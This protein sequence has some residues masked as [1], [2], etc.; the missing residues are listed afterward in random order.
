[1][2]Y[3]KYASQQPTRKAWQGMMNRCYTTTNKDY[4]SV[5]GKGVKVCERWHDYNNFVADMGEKPEGT[6]FTRYVES[7]DF[8]P[9]NCYWQQKVNSR[10][11][12]LYS[13]WKGIRRRCGFTGK[14]KNDTAAANYVN[15]G[16]TMSPDWADSFAAFSEAVGV[17]PTEKHQ[18]DRVDN[19]L[20]YWPG[21][22]R[23]VEPKTNANNRSNNVWIEMPD[24]NG[25]QQRKTVQE[26]CDHFGVDRKVFTSRWR[27]LF[28]PS[29]GKN[30]GVQQI[31][32]STGE[33]IAE[34]EGVKQAAA[35]S[36]IKQTTIAKCL[37]GGNASAGG[38]GW[39]Y[40]K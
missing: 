23:W 32:I 36:G 9:Q 30:W 20:G 34:F 25:I 24:S 39:C 14:V 13:I 3:S 22:V 15:R 29:K 7:M 26:W 19:D 11:N 2:C 37:S 17:P 35:V 8:T 10:S 1:M 40:K 28:S 5:G 6:L 12:R 16:V 18:L 38:Y 4:P 27:Y 21:N 33:V 31:N